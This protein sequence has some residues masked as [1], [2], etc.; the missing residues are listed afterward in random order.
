MSRIGGSSKVREDLAHALEVGRKVTAKVQWI[1]NPMAKHQSRWIHCTPLLGANDSVGVWMVILVEAG[2]ESG[3][4][5]E[6]DTHAVR[7][8]SWLGS[9]YTADALPWD[10]ARQKNNSFGVSTSIWSGEEEVKHNPWQPENAQAKQVVDST[11][12]HMTR[13]GSG[14]RIGGVDYSSPSTGDRGVTPPDN[15]QT[16]GDVGSNILP[17]RSQT[18]ST[19]KIAGRP[20][21]DGANSRKLPINIPGQPKIDGEKDTDGL[22]PTRR[23]YKSLSPYG[24]LFED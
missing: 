7:N 22:I 16:L 2:G 24:I 5:R 15:G 1:S 3:V 14:P 6:Q 4:G 19:V 21:M 12:S 11:R 23:T 13:S 9:N 18:H 20:S 17:V 8:E 10:A